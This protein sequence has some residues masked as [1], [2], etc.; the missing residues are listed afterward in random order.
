[1]KDLYHFGGSLFLCGF[2][3]ILALSLTLLSDSWVCLFGLLTSSNLLFRTQKSV[4]I[5]NLPTDKKFRRDRRRSSSMSLDER[6]EDDPDSFPQDMSCIGAECFPGRK[7]SVYGNTSDTELGSKKQPL[8]FSGP[9]HNRKRNGDSVYNFTPTSSQE[10]DP[11]LMKKLE[12]DLFI[13]NKESEGSSHGSASKTGGGSSHGSREAR[14]GTGQFKAIDKEGS[15]GPGR[16]GLFSQGPLH[17]AWN[18]MQDTYTEV[19]FCVFLFIS[20]QLH[21]TRV[22]VIHYY[23]LNPIHRYTNLNQLPIAPKK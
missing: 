17:A 15:T 9:L 16:N 3:T 23:Q 2:N 7:R 10:L 21:I 13:H 1:M 4:P 14:S 5:V 20:F 12:K 11:N 8:R 18:N 22:Y 6:F 19:S